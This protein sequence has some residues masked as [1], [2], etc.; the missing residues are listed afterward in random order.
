[1][2]ISHQQLI[3]LPVVTQS[4]HDLGS[5]KS[6]NV[7]IDSQSILEYQIKPSGLVKKL[8]NEDLIISRGQIISITQDKII[9]DDNV[10]RHPVFQKLNKI[11]A[12][13]D[14]KQSV[15]VNKE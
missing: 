9:I 14:D 15:A 6:F 5:V 2:K 13:K 7:D 12:K 3:N 10:D 11:L 8:I 4:G 1:M